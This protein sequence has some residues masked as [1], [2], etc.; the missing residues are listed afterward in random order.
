MIDLIDALDDPALF[1]P[2]FAGPSWG[3]WRAVLKAACG[4]WLDDD[5]LTL[6]RQVAQ[7]DPPSRR[8]R[9]L[10]IV[11][12]RRAGKDSIASAIAAH[13]AGFVDYGHVLRP[14]ELASVLCLAV[15][16]LQAKI[17][18]R[19]AKAFF[20]RI[21]MLAELVTRE[22]ADGLDISTNA[23]LSVIASN[24]R[25]V[26]GR[27]IAL[28]ILDECAYWRDETSAS[29]DVETYTALLPGLVT[30]PDS[31]LIGMSSPYRK[32]GLLYTK[33]Q[34]HFGMPHDDVLVIQA[35]SRVLNP[36]LPQRVIDDAMARDPASARAE[37]LAEW[38]DDIA[39]FV[40]REI[41]EAAVD[42]GIVARPPI[43][44]VEYVGFADAAS[45]TG[46]DS[47]GAAIAHAEGERIVVDVAHELRPP[48]NPQTAIAEV[49]AIFS[50]YRI[51]N[52]TGDRWAP[53][54]VAEGFARAGLKYTYSERDRSDIY[55]EALPWLISGNVR[56][57]DNARLVHQL[58][59]LERRTTPSGRD[60]VDHPRGQ[61]NHDDI[62][63]A[64]AG[65]A[66]Q[67]G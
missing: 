37:W 43:P 32:A 4:H 11:A 46:G 55:L 58:A 34:D 26:R 36:T 21:P 42:W 19:Y 14:G 39:A 6:F 59:S 57:L 31:M 7:R 28:A 53:G 12:G 35:A 64:V 50:R 2:W 63:N 33:W 60:R 22:T 45:G 8:V 56:L 49:A 20:E 40:P 10:W 30:V 29:P 66:R 61:A 9:E 23:E 65:V 52:V 17:V 1:Q 18:L 67:S 13:A 25:A 3:P 54:F 24:F 5:E 38:R 41:V 27:S 47:F 15:D 16:K 48:F 44:N 51:N 62:S